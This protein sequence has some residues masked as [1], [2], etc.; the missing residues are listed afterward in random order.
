MTHHVTCPVCKQRVRVQ[1]GRLIKHR[2]EF[3]VC[4]NSGCSVETIRRY[5]AARRG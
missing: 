2:V 3:H 1:D 5:E 4:A